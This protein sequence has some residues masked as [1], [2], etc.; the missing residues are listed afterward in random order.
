[1]A[2]SLII[3]SKP[4]AALIVTYHVKAIYPSCPT[5]RFSIHFLLSMKWALMHG[6]SSSCNATHFCSTLKQ[7]HYWNLKPQY[8]TEFLS[9][10]TFDV[11]FHYLSKYGIMQY[12]KLTNFYTCQ[13]QRS[14]V[15]NHLIAD[16]KYIYYKKILI[17]K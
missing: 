17:P 9:A 5:N 10:T 2:H 6:G 12:S 11:W 16:M 8:E 15:Y 7:R 3:G 13:T 14:L 1:M 4:T